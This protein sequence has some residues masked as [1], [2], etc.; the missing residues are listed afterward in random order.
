MT[1]LR[2]P[3][4]LLSAGQHVRLLTPT[5]HAAKLLNHHH[6]LMVRLHRCYPSGESASPGSSPSTAHL[7]SYAQRFRND[8]LLCLAI[9]FRAELHPCRDPLAC[10]IGC[11][12]LYRP[13]CA[14]ETVVYCGPSLVP[15]RPSNMNNPDRYARCFSMSP[16]LDATRAPK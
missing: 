10:P 3:R 9:R 8:V 2:R 12:Y 5:R 13:P 4:R 6:H 16:T 15:L 1:S 14:M 11:L 7:F